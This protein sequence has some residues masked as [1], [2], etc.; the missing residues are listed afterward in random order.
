[1]FPEWRGNNVEFLGVW[2]IKG[3]DAIYDG[4]SVAIRLKNR[5]IN[6]M[7]GATYRKMIVVQGVKLSSLR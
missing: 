7:N 1:M 4:L 5:R 6:K 3:E 2:K